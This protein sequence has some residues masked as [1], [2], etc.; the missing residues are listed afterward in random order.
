MEM[1]Q[2]AMGQSVEKQID[3]A[4]NNA[5]IN[6]FMISF[7]TAL[8][9][10]VFG[11]IVFGANNNF[12]G[13]A[14]ENT[15]LIIA[16]ATSL[17][18]LMTFGFLLFWGIM[19]STS[20]I[21][22]GSASIGLY[23]PLSR[24]DAGKLAL[25]GYIRLFDAQIFTV[26]FSFPLAYFLATFSITGMLACLF[27][28]L[29]SVGLSITLMLILALYFYSRIQASGGSRLGSFVRIFF[30]LIYAMA[31][32][33]FSLIFQFVGIFIPIIQGLVNILGPFW[34]ILSFIFP[35]SLG[36]FVAQATLLPNTPFLIGG[37]GTTFL[38]AI[39]AIIGIRWS[40]N[41]LVHIGV[42]SIVQVSSSV[43]KPV[44]VKINRP[45]IAVIR[46]DLRVAFRTPG[47]AIMFFLPLMMMVPIVIQFFSETGI[48][49][50]VDVFIL[51]AMPTSILSF[52]AIFFLSIEA[53]GMAYTLTLP[54]KTEIILRA[55][56]QLL[57]LLAAMV[58]S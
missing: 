13:V 10:V 7:F 31:I 57:T 16:V 8:I 3:K 17:F 9:A 37:L 43:I 47:Q 51:V 22:S 35:F 5:R 18:I 50:V 54:L 32:L 45:S 24:S 58:Q 41:F 29:I 39:L 12:F 49:H 11:F 25:L 34:N 30:Y 44:S 6:K 15:W 26:I 53:R 19:V 46:K 23:L 40:G 28:I 20:F 4:R 1:S 56:A 52:F 27:A 48:I 33:G 21:S 42:G 55:K 38:Y 14:P 2:G 36:S